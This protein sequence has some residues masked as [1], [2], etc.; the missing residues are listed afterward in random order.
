M[1]ATIDLSTQQLSD[2]L[3]VTPRMVNIYRSEAER[4]TGKKFGIKRGRVIYFSVE[5]QAEIA[6]VQRQGVDI[7]GVRSQHQADQQRQAEQYTS[8]AN[9]TEEGILTGMDELV[10]AGDQ[11]AIAIG[12]AIGMRW[13]EKLMTAALTTMQ[14]GMVQFSQ[15]FGELNAAVALAA[16]PDQ[17][18]LTGT[19]I[20]TPTLVDDWEASETDNRPQENQ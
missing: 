13:Q 6:R 7:D 17:H 10:A 3:G 20:H 14:Q 5:E 18:Q 15:Q 9:Q 8:S 4:L 2:Q 1:T 11:N 12:Q 16:S 19:G